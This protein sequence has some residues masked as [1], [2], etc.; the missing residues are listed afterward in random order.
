M[1]TS[2]RSSTTR[3]RRPTA[4]SGA[5]ASPPWRAAAAGIGT[6]AEA[7]WAAGGEGGEVGAGPAGRGPLGGGGA[8]RPRDRHGAAGARAVHVEG[9]APDDRHAREREVAAGHETRARARD[10]WEPPPV[11]VVRA[12]GADA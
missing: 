1:T 6:R 10:S 12:E 4:P 5:V 11:H 9:R 3:S 7:A 2:A 8:G